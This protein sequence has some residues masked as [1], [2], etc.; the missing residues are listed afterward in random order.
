MTESNRTC[1]WGKDP[2]RKMWQAD[3]GATF[4]LG[5]KSWSVCRWLRG[6]SSGPGFT[7]GL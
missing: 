1:T 5:I 4:G 6:E 2:D 7:L 3:W